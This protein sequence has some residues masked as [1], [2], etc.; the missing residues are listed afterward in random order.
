MI[1]SYKH[2]PHKIEGLNVEI[3]YFFEKL[4]ENDLEEYNDQILLKPDFVT[5]ISSSGK[6]INYLTQ[7]TKD[8]HQLKEIDK[9]T[10]QNA[11]KYNSPIELL[12]NDP[13]C[14]SPIKF[15]AI[16]NEGFRKLLKD[17]LTDL[18]EDYPIIK[19]IEDNYGLV[20][21]HFNDFIDNNH[22]KAFVCPFCGLHKL[23]PSKAVNR[24]A[25]DHYIPKAFYPFISINYLNLFPICHECNSDE[26]KATDTLFIN[27]TRRKVFY[28]YDTSYRSDQ[29]S[30]VV[31][32]QESYSSFNF[33]T[34]LQD[35]KWNYKFTYEGNS[36]QRLE[37]WDEIFRIKGRYKENILQYQ[38][39]WFGQLTTKY[40]RELKKGTAF[41][42]FK[43]EVINDS[44]DEIHSSPLGILRYIY[45]NFLFSISDFE[46]KLS[47]SIA[48]P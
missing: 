34:L 24:D 23:K 3:N 47:H 29:L 28:P 13:T 41:F 15:T 12:C 21:D 36:D 8:Y 17:F 31:E 22:Q 1:Y 37:S 2:L 39:E 26:K 6:I 30:I 18:W 25:Y 32:P 4:F 48:Q 27:G 35:I 45:F 38:N 43:D 46:D 20:Q 11:F 42:D 33:K 19:A 14:D 5:L 7:L 9:L 40:K 16:Q 44:K 10:L